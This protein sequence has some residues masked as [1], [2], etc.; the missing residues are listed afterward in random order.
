MTRELTYTIAP[1]DEEKTILSFLRERGYSR[2][3]MIHLKRT[4]GSIARNGAFAYAT[5][6]LRAGDRLTVRISEESSSE[7]IVPVYAPLDISF[8]DEDLLVLCKPAGVPTHP[9]M[10]HYEHTLANAL[11]YYMQE[12]GQP[13]IFRCVNRLDRY[14]S[15]L[16]IVA[17]HMLSSAVLSASMRAGRIRREYLGIAE[18]LLPEAGTVS[19][20]IARTSDSVIAREVNF[21]L[22]E[23]AVTHYRRLKY[24]NGLS[25]ASFTLETGRTHQIRVH[26]KYIGHPLIGDFL[27]HPDNRQMERQALH[28]WRISFPHPL[29][30]EELSF[31]APV[32]KDFILR[33]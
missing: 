23:P 15:G 21:A 31:T 12:K 11:A 26:M 7:H 9:S 13:M 2:S 29:T 24:E 19:A 10:R 33:P 20:P 25:L 16:T 14:T 6:R 17:K 30:G 18:G 4:P 27:Y 22:G 32:P 8:E 28:A 3:V 1:E 5:E